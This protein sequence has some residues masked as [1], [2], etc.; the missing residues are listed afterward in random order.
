MLPALAM[1]GSPRSADR[2]NR[3]SQD[4][5]DQARAAFNEIERGPKPS[6]LAT[7]PGD[8]IRFFLL[9]SK[10]HARSRPKACYLATAWTYCK[11]FGSVVSFELLTKF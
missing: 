10:V 4:A 6:Y 9:A 5:G 2:L 7:M 1:V 8:F 3:L 11:S